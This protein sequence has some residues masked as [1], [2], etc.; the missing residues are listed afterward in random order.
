[1]KY[2]S[3][4]ALTLEGLQDDSYCKYQ[5]EDCLRKLGYQAA[6]NHHK[7]E[8]LYHFTHLYFGCTKVYTELP[9]LAKLGEEGWVLD[10]AEKRYTME[11][12]K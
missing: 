4:A 8:T 1:M 5:E 9:D 12:V 3:V 10:F 6:K 11:V 7:C 2:Y